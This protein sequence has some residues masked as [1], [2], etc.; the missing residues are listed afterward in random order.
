MSSAANIEFDPETLGIPSE[1]WRAFCTEHALVH[2]PRVVGGNVYYGGYDDQVEATYDE[3]A[4][5]FST[6][7]GGRAM[8]DVARLAA[9]AWCRWGGQLTAD[10]EIRA[11]MFPRGRVS[12]SVREAAS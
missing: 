4:L 2:N 10:P 3:H 6:Y 9:L 8:P 7:Q 5:C 11:G 12:N 1:E